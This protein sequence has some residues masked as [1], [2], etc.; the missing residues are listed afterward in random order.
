MIM[1][2]LLS[3]TSEHDLSKSSCVFGM[4]ALPNRGMSRIFSKSTMRK[5]TYFRNFS[6][7]EHT[8]LLSSEYFCLMLPLDI[9]YMFMSYQQIVGKNHNIKLVNKYFESAANFK[10]LG[11]ALT[12]KIACTK[13]LR[14]E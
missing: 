13:K 7:P 9:K 2:L 5:N 1:P 8:K 11:R 14:A 6:L 12:I 10:Y 4:M 3:S